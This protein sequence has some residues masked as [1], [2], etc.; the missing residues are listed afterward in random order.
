MSEKLGWNALVLA[1]IV[2]YL[3]GYGGLRAT[4]VL[5][6][7]RTLFWDDVWINGSSDDIKDDIV[8]GVKTSHIATGFKPLC[9]AEAACWKWAH[10]VH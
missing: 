6:R 10:R 5:V 1:V 9:M 8:F 4:D 3:G 7:Y 2:A